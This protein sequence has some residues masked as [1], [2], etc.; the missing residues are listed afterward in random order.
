MSWS[1]SITVEAADDE[2]P[3]LTEEL[4]EQARDSVRTQLDQYE[5]HDTFDAA[6]AAA[7]RLLEY[8]P[9]TRRLSLSGHK[10][11]TNRSASALALVP[12]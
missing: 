9:G 12:E 7:H 3:V 5:E 11:G 10:S 2:L 6:I 1:T 8:G 4:V